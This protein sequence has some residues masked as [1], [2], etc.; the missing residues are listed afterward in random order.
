MTIVA[1]RTIR[2]LAQ[3]RPGAARVLEQFGLDYCCG[4]DRG[5]EE[6]CRTAKISLDHVLDALDAAEY[7][8]CLMAALRDWENE[9]LGELVGHIRSTHHKYTREEVARLNTL[10]AKVHSVHGEKH[11]EL[12]SMQVV[13]HGLAQELGLHMMKEEKILFPYI[14]HVEEA[15]VQKEPIL[16]SPFG[17]VQNPVAMME[18][19]H[20]DALEA[21]R[22]LRQL[23]GNF[24]APADAC[25][26]YRTLY[27]AL[28]EFEADLREHIHLENDILFP[29]AIAMEG[30]RR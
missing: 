2:D 3:E 26:S 20:E 28:G 17:S 7:N 15:V 16:P 25:V 24:T 18:H 11:P 29:R 5:L 6:A 1:D 4:G 10:F 21:L 27:Q 8:A 22:V 12:H 13:F 9:P 19:E 23:S 14:V 30:A